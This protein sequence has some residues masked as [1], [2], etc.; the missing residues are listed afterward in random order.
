MTAPTILAFGDSLTEGYGLASQDSF[1]AQLQALLAP[2]YPG[3]RVINAGVS[4]DSTSDGLKRLPRLLSGMK[5]RPDLAIVEFGANDL[6]RGIPL[7]RT[8][9]N[10]DAMLVEFARCG[11]ATLLAQMEASRFLGAFGEACSAVYTDLAVK[12]GVPVFP[13]FPR[14]VLGNPALCLRDRIHPNA[15]GVGAIARAAVPA[16]A[17]AIEQVRGRRMRGAVA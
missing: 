13:F 5:V 7:Q 14:G 17:A 2:G 3:V 10:L 12:H 1:T 8:R 15:A 16:V 11:I 6:I 9:A 4:G